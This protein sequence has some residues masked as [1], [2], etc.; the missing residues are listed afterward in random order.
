MVRIKLKEDEISKYEKARIIGSR[1]LQISMGA[2][3]YIDLSKE[4][5]EKIKYNVVEIAKK[6]YEEGLIPMEVKRL[7]PHQR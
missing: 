2:P 5:L 3:L 6:E 1:A 7:Y 4:D